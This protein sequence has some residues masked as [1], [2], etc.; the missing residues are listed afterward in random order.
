MSDTTFRSK[1]EAP[2]EPTV[3]ARE[4]T[5]GPDEGGQEEVPYLD[6]ENKNGH[7]YSVEKFEL[8][9][10]WDDPKGGFPEELSVIEDYFQ[11]R[12]ESGEM[13]NSINAVKE[14][15]KEL[16]KITGVDKEERAVVKIEMI[17]AYIKF[18]METDRIKINLSRYSRR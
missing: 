16:E 3:E 17:A 4:Q 7:P 1:V 6:Y 5:M 14:R 10:S 12:I 18:L 9:D 15:Y 11:K 13:A 8:G 2:V